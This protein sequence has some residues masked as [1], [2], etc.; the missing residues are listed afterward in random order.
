MSEDMHIPLNA[1]SCQ[2]LLQLKSC[3]LEN[4]GKKRGGGE[5]KAVDYCCRCKE[6]EKSRLLN[7]LMRLSCLL[8]Q[9]TLRKDLLGAYAQVKEGGSESRPYHFKL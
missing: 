5:K 4:S 8:E 3:W 1:N 9:R 7:F 2:K 6:P